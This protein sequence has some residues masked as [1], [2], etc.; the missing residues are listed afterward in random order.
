MSI[1]LKCIVCGKQLQNIDEAAV[2]QP[3]EGLAFI[4]H[5]HYGGTVFDPMDG[6]YL[7]VNICDEC[8]VN[9][10]KNENVLVGQDRKLVTIP[11]PYELREIPTVVGTTTIHR[12]LVP[13]NPDVEEETDAYHIGSWEDW[14]ET[15]ELGFKIDTSFSDDEIREMFNE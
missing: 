11:G 1:C 8:L 5:G 14:E 7:E 12:E 6:R 15:K 3:Y 9:A 2:N 10:A 13:W 4:S